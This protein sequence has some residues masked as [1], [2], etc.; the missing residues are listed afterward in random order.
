MWPHRN[1]NV[2]SLILVLCLLG[3]VTSHEGRA[4][5][6]PDSSFALVVY[7]GG[8]ASLYVAEI[9]PPADIPST[10]R[11]G[12]ISGSFRVMWHPDHLLRVGLET[13]WTR[14]F[15]YTLR[16][17]SEGNLYLNGIP[18]LLVF[19][20]PIGERLHVFVGAGGYFVSSKLEFEKTVRVQEFSQGWMV[21]AAY[22]F[23]I[24]SSLG[25]ATEL[26]WFNASQF[27]DATLTV[28]AQFVWKFLEW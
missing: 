21:A 19:S 26:K 6:P 23:P 11:R 7:A 16:G 20:M 28:Q 9:N 14:F 4:A 5:L 17:T 13:G 15:S 18:L 24:T 2:H 8:G 1:N 22:V 12:G 25:L 10:V 3:A 27:E